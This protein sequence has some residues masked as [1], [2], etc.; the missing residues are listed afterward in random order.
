VSWQVAESTQ[1]AWN[2]LATTHRMTGSTDFNSVGVQNY[3]S[4]AQGL[5]ATG[6]TLEFGWN[7]YG[8]GDIVRSLRA[9]APATVTARAINASSW[10]PGCVGGEYVLNVVPR[11]EADLGSYLGL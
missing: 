6:E 8:Y 9:C 4:L 5:A 10:C 2:P 11:V 1:A 7:V 3:L